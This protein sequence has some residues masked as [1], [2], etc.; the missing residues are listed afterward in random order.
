MGTLVSVIP[1]VS[2]S[3]VFTMLLGYL[4]FKREIITWQTLAAMALVI[5]GVILVVT[6]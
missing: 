5:P 3:P 4:V 6:T 2:A 1:I